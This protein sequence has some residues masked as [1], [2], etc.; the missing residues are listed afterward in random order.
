MGEDVGMQYLDDALVT[1][2][3][4][5]QLAEGALEQVDAERFFQALDP[6]SNSLALVVKHVAGNQLSRWRHFLTSDGEKAD[7]DRDG[8]FER[9]SGDT[10]ASLMDRWRRGWEMTLATIEG[11]SPE[12][13]TRT[14]T[15]RGEPH[16]VL[17]AIQRQIAHYAYHSGQ[18][19]FLAKHFAGERWQSLSIP[20]G[21]SRDFEVARDGLPYRLPGRS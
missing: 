21:R 13:L 7:R 3:K 12:D 5:R 9:E 17:Q 11:L 20:K 14:V 19:V 8:E 15:I 2:R 4:Y 1:L 18:I 16:T 10:R 6:E